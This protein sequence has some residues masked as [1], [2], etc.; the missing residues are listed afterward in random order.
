MSGDPVFCNILNNKRA[1]KNAF[2]IPDYAMSFSG[3]G[4]YNI[5]YGLLNEFTFQDKSHVLWGNEEE[6]EQNL[7][8]FH[9]N[10][11]LDLEKTRTELIEK[12]LFYYIPYAKLIAYKNV[13]SGYDDR[14]YVLKYFLFD[15]KEFDNIPNERKNAINFLLLVPKYKERF[16][17][18]IY[19]LYEN[20]S[21]HC[22]H[23]T[24]KILA[25]KNYIPMLK[26]CFINNNTLGMRTNMIIEQDFIAMDKLLHLCDENINDVIKNDELKTQLLINKHSFDYIE[27]ISFIQSQYL[28]EKTL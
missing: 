20:D 6:K 26:E 7:E 4:D 19:E 28:L 17:K 9:W 2:L 18:M 5:K 21:F 15:I 1:E 24:L 22:L 23:N 8:G 13:L 10:L 11:I 16:K 12:V 25:E 14:E 3:K 27:H